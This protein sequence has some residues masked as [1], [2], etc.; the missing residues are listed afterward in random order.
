MQTNL[1]T[2]LAPNLSGIVLNVSHRSRA[3]SQCGWL[4]LL[5]LS[6]HLWNNP[7]SFN[8]ISNLKG[9][10]RRDTSWNTAT[11][12]HR[13]GHKQYPGCSP[14]PVL[15]LTEIISSVLRK[16]SKDFVLVLNIKGPTKEVTTHSYSYCSLDCE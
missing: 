5:R 6:P 7:S 11:L 8:Q 14:P 16:S 13:S 15:T 10:Q 12:T 3:A 9:P 1:C 4:D 2:C